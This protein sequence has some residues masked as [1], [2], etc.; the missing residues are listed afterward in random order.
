MMKEINTHE[1][2]YRK[3]GIIKVIISIAWLFEKQNINLVIL[4]VIVIKVA[5]YGFKAW[6]D[7]KI[8]LI[9]PY[10][11]Y[12]LY[13]VF[14]FNTGT[15]CCAFQSE[16]MKLWISGLLFYSLAEFLEKF[17]LGDE[18]RYEIYSCA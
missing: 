4:S 13:G 11:F 12:T 16:W 6:H 3:I 17:E 1:S 14:P 7:Y 5:L 15:S 8:T 2:K 18:M 10:T 9:I